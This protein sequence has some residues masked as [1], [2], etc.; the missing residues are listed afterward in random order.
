MCFTTK[1]AHLEIVSNAT[2]EAFLACL[3]RFVS[4]RGRPTHIYSNNGGTFQGARWHLQELYA[5]L[6]KSTT[7]STVNTYLLQERVQWHS[8]PE[9]APRFGGLWEAAVKSAKT[10]LKKV[11][12]TQRLDYEEF[13]TVAAQVESC[14]NSWPLISIT[15]HSSEGVRI[16]TPG[17]F[18]IGREL[19]AYPELPI[20]SD[21]KLHRRWNLY[22]VI[23]SHF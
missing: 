11:I 20:H 2:T 19:C 14:L 9:R 13:S 1:A 23:T 21:L 6:D 22:Q 5:L 16:L 10:H 15:T 4:Q 12:G 17:H 18:L 7:Q 8:M 3:R